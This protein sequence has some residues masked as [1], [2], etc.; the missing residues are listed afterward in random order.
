M[1]Q[2][3]VLKV[4]HPEF[5]EPPRGHGGLSPPLAQPPP[6]RSPPT[7]A[8]TVYW[9]KLRLPLELPPQDKD[10]RMT[11]PRDTFGG[12]SKAVTTRSGQELSTAEWTALVYAELRRL[13]GHYMQQE[14]VNHT[15]QATA[16]VHE[17]YLRLAD[18]QGIHWQNRS[19]FVAAAAHLMRRVLLDYNRK[20]QSARRGGVSTRVFLE[21]AMIP[22]SSRPADVVALD[23][24]LTRL[25]AV[26]DQHARLVELRFFG[27]LSI[28]EAAGVLEISPATV[29]RH[30]NVAKAWLARELVRGEQSNA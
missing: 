7:A 20:H 12:P 18:Q 23:E 8:P 17:A 5:S 9:S 1:S 14:R 6:P 3:G 25:A 26:D 2:G 29:K 16:L 22:G 27:G 28:D 13:A 21:E 19:Q 10:R 30:W 11:S 24:A 4:T 15:L